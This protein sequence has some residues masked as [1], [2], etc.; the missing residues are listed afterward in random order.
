[1]TVSYLSSQS[2]FLTKHR[3]T[4]IELTQIQT[5]NRQIHTTPLK[6]ILKGV[7]RNKFTFWKSK[8]M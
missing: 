6:T 4:T 2:L 1:M 8:K 7:S 3:V 5:Q